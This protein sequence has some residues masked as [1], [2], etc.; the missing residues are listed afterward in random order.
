MILEVFS[1]LND[2]VILSFGTQDVSTGLGDKTP[3]LEETC[4]PLELLGYP[5]LAY[6]QA[7]MV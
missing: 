6:Y 4:S 1:K 2:S 3:D 5:S 7:S